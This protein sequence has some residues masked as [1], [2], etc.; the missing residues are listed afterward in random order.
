M[1]YKV[2]SIRDKFNGFMHPSLELSEESARR[3]FSLAVS[4]E[5]NGIMNFSPGDFDLYELGNFDSES[6]CLDV[7]DVP[8]FVVN[9]SEVKREK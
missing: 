4:N 7:L 9:G 3:N 8:R 5:N 1:I 6:G 2:F